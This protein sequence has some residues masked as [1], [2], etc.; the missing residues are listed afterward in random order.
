MTPEQHRKEVIDAAITDSLTRQR[1]EAECAN[2]KSRAKQLDE[3]LRNHLEQSLP[4]TV[5]VSMNEIHPARQVAERLDITLE[6]LVAGLVGTIAKTA[7]D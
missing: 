1:N 5:R 4:I 3:V 7:D 6:E 2:D